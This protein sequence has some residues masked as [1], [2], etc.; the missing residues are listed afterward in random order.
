MSTDAEDISQVIDK[1][2]DTFIDH[3]E[4]PRN[5]GSLED[6]DSNTSFTGSCGDTITVWLKVNKD[7]IED[8]KFQTDGCGY[9][10]ACGSMA[11][12]LIRGKRIT[13]VAKINQKRI[14][15]KLG[16]LPDSHKHCALLASSA[17]KEAVKDYYLFKKE[18][19][20]KLY[21]K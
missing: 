5:Y 2:S 18:P 15:D 16:G 19:W 6:Y 7:I 4:R 21:R 3:A 13:D 8:I 20:K 14:I 11:T 9:T 12:S 17:I 10:V 1:I